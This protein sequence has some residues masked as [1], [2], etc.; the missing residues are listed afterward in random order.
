M[1]KSQINIQKHQSSLK[2]LPREKNIIFTLDKVP[3]AIFLNYFIDFI[4]IRRLNKLQQF[5][6][7]IQN[8]FSQQM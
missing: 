8:S 5:H 7:T 6:V 2:A 3:S 1:M 4:Q